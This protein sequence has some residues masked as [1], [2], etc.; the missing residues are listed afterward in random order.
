MS[1][2][3][4][5]PQR[6]TWDGLRANVVGWT[7]QGEVLFASRRGSGRSPADCSPRILTG[8]RRTPL[9]GGGRGRVRRCDALLHAPG[10]E[11]LQHS[12]AG[13]GDDP[14]AVALGR[15]T[16]GGAAADARRLGREPE[17]DA[18]AGGASTSSA[19]ASLDMNIWSVRPDG[20]DA[21]QHTMHEGWDNLD[22][23]PMTAAS[24]T[25]S[26]AWTCVSTTS[27]RTRTS[28]S[29]C[30][31]P[32]PGPRPRAL[33]AEPGRVGHGRPPE[34]ER[35]SGDAHRAR[36]WLWCRSRTAGSSG[37]RASLGVRWRHARFL[38]G[39]QLNALSDH[40]GE[41]EWWRLP[42]N[43]IG[44]AT[45]LTKD[46]TSSATTA[47]RPPTAAGLRTRTATRRC[48]PSTSRAAPPHPPREERGVGRPAR[49]G[50][51]AGFAPARLRARDRQPAGASARLRHAHAQRRR[52]DERAL[53]QFQPGVEPGRQV[54]MVPLR[55]PL[56]DRGPQHLGLA[57]AR[58]VLR[59]AHGR[60][61]GSRC[62]RASAH[63][64]PS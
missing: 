50:V 52:G 10:D 28:R 42:A 48:A 59:P 64:G 47:S 62:R 17:R 27:R 44:S 60:C 57:R 58:S 5:S 13:R 25:S 37:R 24:S 9:R 16:R 43:G 6:L 19:T 21:R 35:R 40:G 36:P 54:A 38:D 11:H 18:V 45:Q 3:V 33:G 49:L 55:P 63:R 56:R 61:S 51:V 1:M 30:G 15:R 7:P 53:G 22:A 8:V 34:P 4:A 23:S 41:V 14:A 31:S 46:A 26:A 29:T 39:K 20:S 12:A 2:A 32:G